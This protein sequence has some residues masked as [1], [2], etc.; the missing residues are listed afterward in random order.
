MKDLERSLSNIHVRYHR[1]GVCGEGFFAI[2]FTYDDEDDPTYI[3]DLI[4]IVPDE[5]E[6]N[7]RITG[8]CYIVKPG[9]PEL[10]YRGDN[11]EPS[12]REC[13]AAERIEFRR[14]VDESIRTGGRIPEGITFSDIDHVRRIN[15]GVINPVTGKHTEFPQ[16]N[17]KVSRYESVGVE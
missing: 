17:K 10:G 5:G 3:G 2:T 16:H 8:R 13:I 9:A 15:A 11:F 4:G 1:N 6:D 12:L 14:V 7:K